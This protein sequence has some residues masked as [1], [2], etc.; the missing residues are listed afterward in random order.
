MGRQRPR[1][2]AILLVGRKRTGVRPK[3]VPVKNPLRS[4]T[5]RMKKGLY[6]SVAVIATAAFLAGSPVRVN[7]QQDAQVSIGTTD[8]GGVVRG[9]NGPEAG[10]WVIAETTD[11]PTKFAKIVVTDDR[12]RYVLPELPKANYLVW[13]RGYGLVDSAKVATAPGRILDLTADP[14]PSQAAAAEYYP[15]I[16][17]WSML[18]I[19]DK[20]LFPG[21]GPQG[22]GIPTGLRSQSRWLAGIK[23][24]GCYSCHQIGNKATRTIPK[25]LGR[26][27]SSFEA[28]VR[29]VQSGMASEIMARN[30][31]EL[32]TPRALKLFADWTDRIAAGE[33]PFARPERPQGIE[34]NVV[35]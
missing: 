12:G 18:R 31:G 14:A 26:F 11:L 15:A 23:T 9:P 30:L 7:A 32:D 6:L 33:L 28:W 3:R 25:E 22:N 17:W 1:Q 13:V 21:S 27:D 24:F 8:L 5:M 20:S 10:V 19:P 2:C 4:N 35:V 29:R 34:R 16:Y